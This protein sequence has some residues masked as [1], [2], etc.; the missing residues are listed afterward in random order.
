MAFGLIFV[1]LVC[2]SF[3]SSGE[4]TFSQQQATTSHS[5]QLLCMQ[6]QK[7][8]GCNIVPDVLPFPQLHPG[9][10]GALAK[11]FWG[12]T[13]ELCQGCSWHCNF[14]LW[15]SYP[16][17]V[18]W[19]ALRRAGK[20][21]QPLRQCGHWCLWLVHASLY[22]CCQSF[23]PNWLSIPSCKACNANWNHQHH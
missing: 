5:S 8:L 11:P 16:H 20:Q 4:R 13:K 12:K 1:F 17:S 10:P 15:L 9:F 23:C 2:W 22:F 14:S 6:L 18:Q 19:N 7:M 21:H 3:D